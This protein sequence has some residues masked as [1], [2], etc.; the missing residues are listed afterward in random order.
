MISDLNKVIENAEKAIDNLI[1]IDLQMEA[2]YKKF[3]FSNSA[4][5][6]K[7]LRKYKELVE[8]KKTWYDQLDVVTD[9]LSKTMSDINKTKDGKWDKFLIQQKIKKME[10][11]LETIYEFE[12]NSKKTNIE[13]I[14]EAKMKEEAKEEIVENLTHDEILDEAVKSSKFFKRGKK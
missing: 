5:R 9:Y 1:G 6:E 13:E 8:S 12:E 3:M 2:I 7:D 10:K 14:V 4:K 11:M